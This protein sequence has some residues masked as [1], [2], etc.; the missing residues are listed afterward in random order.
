MSIKSHEIP[1]LEFS[2][3]LAFK[4]AKIIDNEY[5][6]LLSDLTDLERLELVSKFLNINL[7]LDSHLQEYLNDACMDRMYAESQPFGAYDA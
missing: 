7:H 2:Q 6:L 1:L 5:K 4:K 3:S